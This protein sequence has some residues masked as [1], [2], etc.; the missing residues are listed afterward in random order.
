VFKLILIT[1]LVLLLIRMIA[2]SVFAFYAGVYENSF[3]NPERKREGEVTI[4]NKP[5]LDKKI[6]KDDGQ[7]VDYEEVK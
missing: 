6:S 5:K 4:E 2:Q 3:K 7:Y 1:L